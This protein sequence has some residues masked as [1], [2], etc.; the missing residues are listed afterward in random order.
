M[1]PGAIARDVF[2]GAVDRVRESGIPHYK[3][4]HVGHGIGIET[5]DL[6]ILT[7]STGIPLEA[8]MITGRQ[9]F[10]DVAAIRRDRR[11]TSVAS[12]ELSPRFAFFP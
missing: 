2:Q 4:H 6:P 8:G 5:Y 12:L 7:P 10:A 1:R 9:P 3:R 11:E